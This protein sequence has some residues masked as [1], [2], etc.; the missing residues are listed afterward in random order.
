MRTTCA[1]VLCGIALMVIVGGS[2]GTVLAQAGAQA[3][4]A[5]RV[6]VTTT[7]LKPDMVDTWQT[8][9]RTEVVPATKKGGGTWRWVFTSGPLGGQG[10][11]FVTVVPITNYAQFDGQNAVQRALGPDGVAKL[12]AKQ[13]PAIV[14]THAVLQTL[15]QNA[16]LQSFPSTPP[17]FVRVSTLQLLPGKGQ[18]FA[19]MIEKE[20]LPAMK[21]AGVTDYLVFAAN[22]GAPITQ[23]SIVTF[24]TKYA[25]LD[26]AGGGPLARALGQ[27]AAQKINLRQAA[28]TSSNEAAVYRL[29]PDLSFGAPAR[30]K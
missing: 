15:V 6:L 3:P 4:P 19:A 26:Q 1:A 7:Q 16:S 11:T 20:Y 22:Y 14:S 2:N 18:E 24:L 28:L 23:R 25:D 30:P 12:N 21:K 27:E 8:I 17:A 5:V 13:R 9:Q 29:V 10:F